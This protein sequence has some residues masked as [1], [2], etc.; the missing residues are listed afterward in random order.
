MTRISRF[1]NQT[2]KEIAGRRWPRLDKAAAAT[3]ASDP[4]GFDAIVVGSGVG[5]LACAACLAKFG[6]KRVLVLESHYRAGAFI[7]IFA[8][9]GN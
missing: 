9:M 6:G 8:L 5:G 2:R 7:L 3:L 4:R 1:K